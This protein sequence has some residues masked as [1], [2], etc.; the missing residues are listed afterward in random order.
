MPDVRI[1]AITES[2]LINN[3]RITEAQISDLLTSDD[4]NRVKVATVAINY[5]SSAV[6]SIVQEAAE[7]DFAFN[8]L[9]DLLEEGNQPVKKKVLRR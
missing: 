9:F 4:A 7:L 2:E 5:L 6:S 8:Q 1:S 3:Y